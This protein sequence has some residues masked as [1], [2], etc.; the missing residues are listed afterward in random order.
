[1][2]VADRVHTQ[3]AD[4][5]DGLVREVVVNS[6]TNYAILETSTKDALDVRVHA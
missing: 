4:R 2:L 3:F 1:M 6:I 5:S